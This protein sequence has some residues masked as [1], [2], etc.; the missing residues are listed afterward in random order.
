MTDEQKRQAM[1]RIAR[2]VRS[3]QNSRDYAD[4]VRYEELTRA[5]ERKLDELRKIEEAR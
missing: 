2:Q 3:L 5:I 4:E 1:N